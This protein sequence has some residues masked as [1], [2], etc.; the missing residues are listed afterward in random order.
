[1]RF[2]SYVCKVW[3]FLRRGI[4]SDVVFYPAWHFIRVVFYPVWYFIRIPCEQCGLAQSRPT[5][6]GCIH[7]TYF[8]ERHI[9]NHMLLFEAFA[10]IFNMFKPRVFIWAPLFISMKLDRCSR[11]LGRSHKIKTNRNFLKYSKSIKGFPSLL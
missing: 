2:I 7:I 10:F 6:Y 8:H 11:K 5:H 1:M 9:K 4:L 3:Y